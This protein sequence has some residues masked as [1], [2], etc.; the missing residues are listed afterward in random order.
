[1]P[2]VCTLVPEHRHTCVTVSLVA[3]GRGRVYPADPAHIAKLFSFLQGW[4]LQRSQVSVPQIHVLQGPSARLQKAAATPVSPQ[5]LEAVLL[6]HATTVH[7]VC[8]RAQILTASVATVCLDSRDPTVNWTLMSVHPGLATMGVPAE[9]WRITMSATA[10]W[11]MQVIVSVTLEG[12][13]VDGH[14]AHQLLIV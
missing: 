13:T 1:M 8:P 7:C 2:L 11:A 14:G 6:N 4:F 9:I 3:N 10:P 12:W 5:S